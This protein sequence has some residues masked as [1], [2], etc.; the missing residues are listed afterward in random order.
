VQLTTPAATVFV[1]DSAWSRPTST[2]WTSTWSIGFDA[3]AAGGAYMVESAATDDRGT[4]RDF[5][6]IGSVTTARA[7]HAASPLRNGRVLVVGGFGG[8]ALDS[9]E[10]YK[11]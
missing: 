2:K 11:Q 5:E 8:S 4:V 1:A 7:S 6:V 3:V 10:L 9:A